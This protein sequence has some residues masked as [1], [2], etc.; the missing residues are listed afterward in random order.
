MAEWIYFIHAP[1][2]DLAATMTE[3]AVWAEHFGRA[4]GPQT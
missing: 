4:V 1:R 3:R 2:D